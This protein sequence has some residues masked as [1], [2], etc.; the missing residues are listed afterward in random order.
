MSAFRQ[1]SEGEENPPVHSMSDAR[2]YSQVHTEIVSDAIVRARTIETQQKS[3]PLVWELLE[4][5][6]IQIECIG[7]GILIRGATTIGHMH[8]GINFEGPVFGPALIEAYEM[9]D[10]E[11]IYPSIAIHEDILERHRTNDWLWRDG[12]SYEH[13]TETLNK[14]LCQDGSGFHFIDYLRASLGEV[15]DEYAGWLTFLGINRDLVEEGLDTYQSGPIRRKFTW[16]KSYHN[17]VI[18]ERI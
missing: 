4:L 3:G 13:E 9:E 1:I 12:H 10:S 11:V 2:L 6:N 17:S 8:L 7:R 14:I 18:D 15:D 5:L 16:L